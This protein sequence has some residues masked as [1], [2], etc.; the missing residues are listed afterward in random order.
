MERVLERIGGMRVEVKSVQKGE[1]L[2]FEGMGKLEG[3]VRKI[4]H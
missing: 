1:E 3:E 4:M 2:E